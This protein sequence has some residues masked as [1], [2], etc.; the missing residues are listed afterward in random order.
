MD[1]RRQSI[2]RFAVDQDL[3]LLQLVGAVFLELVIQR[4]I[5]A[6]AAFQL[7][8]KVDDDLGERDFEIRAGRGAER[9]IPGFYKCRAVLV[10][11]SMIGP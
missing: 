5:P 9:G 7:I 6:R 4:G 1:D 8:E 11:R 10:T 3:E 2:H